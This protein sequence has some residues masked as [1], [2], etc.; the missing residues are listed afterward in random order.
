MSTNYP[1]IERHRAELDKCFTC[2]ICHAVCPTYQL[3]RK[4]RLSPRGR[5][6]LLR[7]LLDGSI[8]SQDISGDAFDYCTLCYACQTACPAG[9]KTDLLFIAARKTI[10][11]SNGISGIKRRIFD[12]LENQKK[13]NSSVRLGSIAQKTLGNGV[14]QKLTKADIPTLRP[15]PF[16]QELQA[17]VQADGEKKCRVAFFLGCVSN[18][19]DEKAATTSIEVLK[20]LGAEVVIPKAQVCCGA[21]AF[22]NGDF[23]TARKLAIK[24]LHL[25]DD[26]N[27]D[28][29]VSPDATCGGAFSHEIPLLMEENDEYAQLAYR[30]KQKVIDWSSLVLEKLNPIFPDKSSGPVDISIHDSCHLT[31]AQGVHNKVRELLKLLPDVNIVEMNESTICCGFGGSFSSLYPEDAHKWTMRKLNNM[32]ATGVTTVIIGSPG[33]IVQVKSTMEKDGKYS[34]QLKHPAEFIAERCGWL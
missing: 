30:I 33:C 24:N 13:T 9:V 16:L 1:D 26:A 34:L 7:R 27:V 2:G 4:E 12:T 3:S 20:R 17:E 10:A 31:H 18:Y 19:V 21:P 25:L 28:Y 15:R 29:I 32:V 5:I 23:E 6:V 11:D 8:D 14:L 22:N